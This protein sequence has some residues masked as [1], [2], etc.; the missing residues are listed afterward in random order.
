MRGMIIPGNVA[1]G[2]A[3][4]TLTHLAIAQN[5][6]FYRHGGDIEFIQEPIKYLMGSWFIRFKEYY[7]MPRGHSR[8]IYGRFSGKKENFNVF[9]SGG[10]HDNIQSKAI[11]RHNDLFSP[12][13]SFSR[14]T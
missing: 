11:D 2:N 9:F 4:A 12:L 3:Y 8:S 5:R 1:L 13:Q 10:E 14:K 7:G 6:P